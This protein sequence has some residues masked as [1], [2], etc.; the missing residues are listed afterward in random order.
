[1][2]FFIRS[3]APLRTTSRALYRPAATFH[4]STARWVMTEADRGT[5]YK[6][7]CKTYPRAQEHRQPAKQPPSF[8]FHITNHNHSCPLHPTP[9]PSLPPPN[10]PM[11]S[12]NNLHRPPRPRRKNRPPQIRL[13]QQ[14][15]IR[16][17]RMEARIE[18]SL[19]TSCQGRQT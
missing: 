9:C 6:V 18:L 14:S 5:L 8:H 16:Q 3:F 15:Q 19:R 11:P 10:S 12:T 1:M 2:T 13:H 17:R 4:T 7:L